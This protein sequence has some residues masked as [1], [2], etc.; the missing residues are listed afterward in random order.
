MKKKEGFSGQRSIVLPDTIVKAM[1]QDNTTRLLHITDMGYYPN[2]RHHFRQREKGISSYILIY[3]VRGK[4]WY[5]IRDKKK[6]VTENQ[7]FILPPDVPHSYGS[8]EKEPWTIYWIHFK[9]SSAGLFTE[10]ASNY[11]KNITPGEHSQIE[12][13]NRLFEKIFST[14][15]MGYSVERLQYAG[16]CLHYYLASLKYL[17]L[18]REDGLSDSKDMD[19]TTLS[20]HYMRENMERALKVSDIADALGIS[21]SYYASL[22]QQCTGYTPITYLTNLRIQKACQLLEFSDMK[23]NQVC[24]ETGYADPFYFSRIFKKI[25]GMSPKEYK[26]K[27]FP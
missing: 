15:E 26:K 27:Y 21:T 11:P 25:M 6:D 19:Y 3:C 5:R 7:F 20:I 17:A 10:E 12:Y 9:G 8:D 13:R 22:F 1:E 16:L 23:I 18:F 2:A 24:Y 4:G 14:L